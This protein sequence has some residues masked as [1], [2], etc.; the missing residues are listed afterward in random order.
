MGIT[1]KCSQR[2]MVLT[3]LKKLRVVYDGVTSIKNTSG[4]QQHGGFVSPMA[5]SADERAVFE[6]MDVYISV[7]TF[8]KDMPWLRPL[9]YHP[10]DHRG[11]IFCNAATEGSDAWFLLPVHEEAFGV[12]VP[13]AGLQGA[14]TNASL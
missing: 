6:S 11:A 5:P 14:C 4:L 2:Y 1:N 9:C 13:Q 12:L 10:V 3:D 8:K 7:T